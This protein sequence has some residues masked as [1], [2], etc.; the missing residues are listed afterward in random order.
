MRTGVWCPI[1]GAGSVVERD[2]FGPRSALPARPPAR[3]IKGVGG[4]GLGERADMFDSGLLTGLHACGYGAWGGARRFYCWG[5]LGMLRLS[6][7][8]HGIQGF[9]AA[10][11]GEGSEGI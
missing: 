3:A 6:R 4:I 9:E 5:C 10:S 2:H 8:F 7:M 1:A 11:F